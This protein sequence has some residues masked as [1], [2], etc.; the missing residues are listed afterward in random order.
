MGWLRARSAA[1]TRRAGASLRGAVAREL[2]PGGVFAEHR[3]LAA[4]H[5]LR[6][7]SCW[8]SALRRLVADRTLLRV[9]RG[10]RLPGRVLV[11]ATASG[12]CVAAASAA[13]RR[14]RA[15]FEW[16]IAAALN[17]GEYLIAAAL[18][19][20][21]VFVLVQIVALVL[22]LWLGPG[23]RQR[24]Q[25]L[26]AHGAARA[27]GIVGPVRD[28]EPRAV[29]GHQLRRRPFQGHERGAVRR[30]SFSAAAIARPPSSWRRAL[31]AWAHSSRRSWS[32]SPC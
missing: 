16:M 23:A 9:A 29:V 30:R 1:A 26:D 15:Q 6:C 7:G 12:V 13:G 11:I 27:G 5:L 28:A 21:A 3:G 31:K 20:W 18:L 17:V 2:G 24:R 22:G 4:P 14:S 25:G 19:V 8:R 32:R 10:V